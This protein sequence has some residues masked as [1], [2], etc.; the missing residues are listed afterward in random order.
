MGQNNFLDIEGFNA[1][2]RRERPGLRVAVASAL[3][4]ALVAVV[5]AAGPYVAGGILVLVP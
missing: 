4:G 5:W 1:R 3:L 2:P